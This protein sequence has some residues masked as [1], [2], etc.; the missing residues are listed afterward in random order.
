LIGVEENPE[1]SPYGNSGLTNDG[2][3]PDVATGTRASVNPMF[4]SGLNQLSAAALQEKSTVGRSVNPLADME[5][6]DA[7]DSEDDSRRSSEIGADQNSNFTF[8]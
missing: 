5:N 3:T 8:S 7:Y 1:F 4:A 2:F 6:S